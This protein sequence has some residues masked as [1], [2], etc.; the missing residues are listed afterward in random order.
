MVYNVIIYICKYSLTVLV[1]DDDTYQDACCL[2]VFFRMK[3]MFARQ[4]RTCILFELLLFGADI[5]PL[6]LYP[7]TLSSYLLLGDSRPSVILKA[8]LYHNAEIRDLVVGNRYT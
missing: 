4:H 3:V 5:V 6:F 2:P 8:V 7:P 1:L